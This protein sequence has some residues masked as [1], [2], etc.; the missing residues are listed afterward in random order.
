MM[1]SKEHFTKNLNHIC[2]YCRSH[3]WTLMWKHSNVR[4]YTGVLAAWHSRSC[5]TIDIAQDRLH[6]KLL[7]VVHIKHDAVGSALKPLVISC[8]SCPLWN[9]L[10]HSKI[11]RWL[12][13]SQDFKLVSLLLMSGGSLGLLLR[14]SQLQ[15]AAVQ[16]S[17]S[18]LAT[19]YIYRYMYKVYI[20]YHW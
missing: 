7:L 19:P 2:V 11:V 10:V 14:A 1:L 4:C 8:C 3:M 15:P 6:T 18:C 16:E 9:H 12:W 20:G 5:R 13:N 17:L